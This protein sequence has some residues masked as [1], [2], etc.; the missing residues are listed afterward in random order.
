MKGTRS[1]SRKPKAWF[2]IAVGLLLVCGLSYLAEVKI[3]KVQSLPEIRMQQW[4]PEYP[5]PILKTRSVAVSI[6]ISAPKMRCRPTSP[7]R[8]EF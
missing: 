2:I 1:F 3:H 6:R 5:E 4:I 8:P 7:I